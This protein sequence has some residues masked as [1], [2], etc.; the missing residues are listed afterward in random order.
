MSR[1]V[2]GLFMNAP[3]SAPSAKR[4]PAFEDASQ[5]PA[6]PAHVQEEVRVAP[7]SRQ[8]HGVIPPD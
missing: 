5:I 1:F 4:N 6:Q 2:T 8:P 3:S 7:Q